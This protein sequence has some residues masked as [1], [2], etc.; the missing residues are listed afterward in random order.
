MS[1]PES[2]W[3]SPV[4]LSCACTA[5]VSSAPHSVA[6]GTIASPVLLTQYADEPAAPTIST[7]TGASNTM[8]VSL[9]PTSI[10]LPRS[11]ADASAAPSAAAAAAAPGRQSDMYSSIRPSDGTDVAF[12]PD[13]RVS[14][15]KDVL[16]VT[17]PG[18][19][20][21]LPPAGSGPGAGPARAVTLIAARTASPVP[22]TSTT[23]TKLDG[24]IPTTGAGPAGLDTA[25]AAPAAATGI[26]S[27]ANTYRV[28]S[29]PVPSRSAATAMLP[30]CVAFTPGPP[31]ATVCAAVPRPPMSTAAAARPPGPVTAP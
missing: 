7:R 12:T 29:G 23:R 15:A 27:F 24:E 21:A 31:N 11:S 13:G 20:V 16:I 8:R 2:A 10:T 22:A 26:A 17:S 30:D 28:R 5:A 25:S 6:I 9:S 14:T 18:G 4:P 19:N 1:A 3:Q